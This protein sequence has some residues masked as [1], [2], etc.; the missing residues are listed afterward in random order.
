MLDKLLI[1]LTA[2]IK[3]YVP[4][5]TEWLQEDMID[6][7]E[8]KSKIDNI[9]LTVMID[10][11]VPHGRSITGRVAHS[12]E[13][14]YVSYDAPLVGVKKG[15]KVILNDPHA[16]VDFWNMLEIYGKERL[17]IN[18]LRAKREVFNG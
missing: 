4:A 5:R 11:T 12:N 9:Q 7:M 17:E 2:W 14:G 13:V 3:K 15:E 1:E 16:I 10:T 18:Y 6:Y 8:S